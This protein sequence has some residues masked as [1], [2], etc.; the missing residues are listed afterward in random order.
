MPLG[1]G[2]VFAGYT[3]VRQL[4]SGGMGE[5]YLAEHPRLPRRDALKVLPQAFTTDAGYRARFHREADLA[6]TLWHPHIVGVHDRGETDGQLWIAMDF[7]DGVDAAQL[8]ADR[9]P[10]GMPP[11][12]AVRIVSAV[13]SALDHAHKRGLLHRDVK[14]ANIML[15]HLDDDDGEQ[16]IL[17]ADFGIARDIGEVSGITTTNMTVGT[18]AYAAPEQ[19]MGED[20]DGRS[21]QYALAATAYHL[22]TGTTLFPHS[23]PAVVISRHL[24]T[25]PPL[26][27]ATRPELHDLDRVL[28][29]A[30]NKDPNDRY[31]RCQDLARALAEPIDASIPAAVA[32][33][34]PAVPAAPKFEPTQRA[35]ITSRP[36]SAAAPP[37]T[38]SSG[39][40]R[41]AAIA[42]A[43]CVIL[44]AAI[45][46]AVWRPWQHDDN[47]SPGPSAPDA[48]PLPSGSS[49]TRSP[50]P[51]PP[52]PTFAASS[53][54]SVLLSSKEINDELG[55]YA[56]GSTPMMAMEDS[57]YGMSDNSALVTP[58]ACV[59]VVFGAEHRVYADT[60]FEEMRDQTFRPEPYV[61]DEVIQPPYVVEQTVVVY[62]TGQQAQAVLNSSQDQWNSC[63]KDAVTERLPPEDSRDWVLGAVQRNGNL[64]T[65]P[66]AANSHIG[67]A[68]CQQ[69]LGA[70]DNVVVG[71]RRC[72]YW[73]ESAA[74]AFTGSTW[75]TNPNWASDDA[76]RL[77]H[78]ML[79]KVVI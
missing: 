49:T 61:V 73:E 48:A 50:L 30:L 8:L 45:G 54:E 20:L 59:G 7:V 11:D 60:G 33:T 31:A 13:A 34:R 69:A 16:R 24:S 14:P 56:A 76:E 64:V 17:L 43:G 41:T 58:S 12:L 74:T 57:S 38:P 6:S 63:A 46:L 68:A 70:R 2:Q 15:T 3:I 5:V 40:R 51:P 55:T 37:S 53:I 35:P 78:L 67:P 29:A 25:A 23:M 32:P 72:D 9:Y 77:A 21:D 18:V 1:N 71:A 66:M 27:S 52:P 47:T 4:G 19:L 42:V 75:P 28:S 62:P 39:R 36:P 44:I 22:L 79:D 26:L 65:V 10:N